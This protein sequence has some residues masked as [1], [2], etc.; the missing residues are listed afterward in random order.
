MHGWH[1][2]LSTLLLD[3]IG[4]ATDSTTC[5]HA[6]CIHISLYP[7]KCHFDVQRWRCGRHAALTKRPG[8]LTYN[9]RGSEVGVTEAIFIG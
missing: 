1:P 4:T 2:V 8:F 6:L 9:E 3:E 5:L 7:L